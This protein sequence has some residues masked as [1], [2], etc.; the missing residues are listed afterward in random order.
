MLRA[1][2]SGDIY[3]TVGQ[4]YGEG[5][6]YSL[7]ATTFSA[8]EYADDHT[9]TTTLATDASPRSGVLNSPIDVDAMRVSLESGQSYV[10]AL[11]GAA[12]GNGSVDDLSMLGFRLMDG[13]D[14][15]VR[16]YRMLAG[17]DP[18]IAFT[19][20]ASGDYFLTVDGR[21]TLGS[22]TVKAVNLSLDDSAPVLLAQSHQQGAT[23]VGLGD[24]TL[25]FR[26]DE[27][28]T[29]DRAAITLVDSDG[30]PVKLAF[31]YDARGPY[32]NDNTLVVKV[33]GSLAPGSYTLSMPAAA[34][35]DLAGH[36]HT[37]AQ[38]LT[39]TTVL[40]AAAASAGDDLL[41][42]G[43]GNPIDGGAGLDTVFVPF[44][45]HDYRVVLE[46]QKVTIVGGFDTVTEVMFNVERLQFNNQAYA[47]DIDG[48]GGQAYRLYQAAFDRAPDAVGVGYWMAQLDH[49]TSLRDVARDFI[50]STEFTAQYGSASSDAQANAAAN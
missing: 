15:P 47:V 39:F 7:S 11:L 2:E 3:L 14:A 20:T 1:Q 40:P 22:Y 46:G 41:A 10:F 4:M 28:I 37:A 9:T 45:L 13:A 50:A 44:D 49:G 32:V 5:Q 19:P 42:A 8:D 24:A 36:R 31:A 48:H 6:Q 16:D 33:D 35:H 18:R 17:A 12:S 43:S 21:G 34:I 26:F 23:G 27:S 38:T 29:I 25:S 30:A